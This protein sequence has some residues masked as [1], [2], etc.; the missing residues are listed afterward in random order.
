MSQSLGH[1]RRRKLGR[2][3]VAL[4]L[5]Q[6][7]GPFRIRTV[8]VEDGIVGILPAL[9]LQA[10]DGFRLVLDKAVAVAVAEIV[11]PAQRRVDVRPDLG[12]GAEVA[13]RLQVHSR[14][15][16][17]ERRRIHASVITAEG[18]LAEMG[19][20]AVA[21]LVKDLARLRVRLAVEFLRLHRR[22]GAQHTPGDR[23]VHPQHEHCGKDPV[24]SKDRAEPGNARV[25]VGTVL[26]R[27]GEH[28]EIGGRA[29][30]DLVEDIA[31]TLHGGDMARLVAPVATTITISPKEIEHGSRLAFLAGD[32][33]EDRCR[34]AGCECKLECCAVRLQKPRGRFKTDPRASLHIVEA[35]I[36]KLDFVGSHHLGGLVAP[37]LSRHPANFEQVAKVRVENVVDGQP[38]IQRREIPQAEPLVAYPLVKKLRALEEDRLAGQGIGIV[39]DLWVGEI[40]RQRRLVV[41]VGRVQ[42]QQLPPLEAKFQLRKEPGVAEEKPFCGVGAG[43]VPVAIQECERIAVFEVSQRLADERGIHVEIVPNNVQV[44]FRADRR[45]DGEYHQT[46]L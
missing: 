46:G 3:D 5:A 23:R 36:A 1:P 38:A 21:H 41:V 32:G 29:R 26:G 8:L 15:H 6:R 24:A 16:D 9:V 44:I 27:G 25:R 7:D 4:D 14:Q 37:L 35:E 18:N 43:N 30:C 31:R 45:I 2:E 28:V 13:R 34:L 39:I 40:D 12:N 10:V 20:L 42:E 17:E 22:Q 19:H 11:Y 33:H